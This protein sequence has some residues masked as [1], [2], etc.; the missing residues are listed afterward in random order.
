MPI[1]DQIVTASVLSARDAVGGSAVANIN[2]PA[3]LIAAGLTD[4]KIGDKLEINRISKDQVLVKNIR[5]GSSVKL[6]YGYGT[7]TE[8][9]D[10]YLG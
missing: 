9:A 8:V 7:G 1:Q 5:T 6:G 3:K 4:A 2:N 10:G